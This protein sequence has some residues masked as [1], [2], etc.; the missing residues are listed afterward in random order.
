MTV[1]FHGSFG[2]R[3][4]Y[5]AGVLSR[6]LKHPR[7]NDAALAK[8]FGYG[9][10]FAA[11][12]RSW[13]HKVG[14]VERGSPIRLAPSGKV[15]VKQ[16]PTLESSVTQWWLHDELTTDPIRAE[17]WHYFVKKFLPHNRE[18]TK[19]ELLDSLTEKLSEHSVKHFGP[20]SALTRTIVRKLL[21]CYSEDYALGELG[22]IH[23]VPGG[24]RR[25][26]TKGRPG[27]WRSP[28]DLVS[29]YRKRRGG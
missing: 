12:C 4:E 21:E 25:G 6:G 20:G 29:A 26:D 8:P 14:L 11:K 1:Y 24:F 2:L 10:P 5:L 17:A 16:D 9:A 22:V 13:L 15:V 19:Q 27:P 7:A 23:V 18:F 3:R 28:E